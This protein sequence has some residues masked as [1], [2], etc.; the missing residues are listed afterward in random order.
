M[1]KKLIGRLSVLGIFCCCAALLAAA[2]RP[3]QPAVH[4]RPAQNA[5]TGPLAG[6]VILVDAGHGGTDGGA[7]AKDSGVWEK[8]LNLQT[9]LALENL[10]E[11]EGAAVIM[12]RETDMQYSENKRTDL[13]A[14]L[15]LAR[16]GGADM[17]VS[18][19]MNE[20]RTRRE[21]GPQ[22]FYRAGQEDSR[23]LA[24]CIQAAMIS[25]L[26]P[27]KERTAMAGDYFILSLNIPSVLVECGFISNSAEEALLRTPEYRE[28]VA[29]GILDGILE[30]YTLKE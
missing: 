19:H 26:K 28:K 1:K 20:Y 30:Y 25:E 16:E 2:P 8:E 3:A 7:R 10:L 13:T 15:D 17:V 4:A 29:Q 24:G 6:R 14:R 12:T 27:A 22:V 23:L 11:A 21:S 5:E 18:I 9:A